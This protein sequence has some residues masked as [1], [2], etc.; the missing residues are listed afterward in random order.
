VNDSD[1]DCSCIDVNKIGNKH[2]IV[3]GAMEVQICFAKET[4]VLEQISQG[5]PKKVMPLVDSA[6][7][8]GDGMVPVQILELRT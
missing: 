3:G 5:V 7:F 4:K 2:V 8:A 1:V 6:G